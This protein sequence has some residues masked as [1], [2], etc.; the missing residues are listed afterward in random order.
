M[1][2]VLDKGQSFRHTSSDVVKASCPNSAFAK[3]PLLVTAWAV[4]MTTAR[5]L[6]SRVLGN[7][8]ARIWSRG[9]SGDAPVDGDKASCP[10]GAFA[11]RP[12]LVTAWAVLMT[13]AR[14]LRSR[15]FLKRH[16]RI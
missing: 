2:R 14:I 9:G 3:L 12:I 16:A 13:T 7:S 10:N 4:L 6:R 5:I 15:V 8:H 11:K 1:V